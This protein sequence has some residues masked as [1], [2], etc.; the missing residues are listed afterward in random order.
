MFNRFQRP[1]LKQAVLELMMSLKDRTAAL[2]ATFKDSP[3][4]RDLVADSKLYSEDTAAQLRHLGLITRIPGTLKL[5]LRSS[6][7][8]CGGT[9]GNPSTT[10]RSITAL[11]CA[12]MAWPSAGGWSALR[13]PWNELRP[14]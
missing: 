14:A 11:T 8:P 6:V 12:I 1:D 7:K 5:G 13:P 10:R 9:P 2:F 3:P 4:P